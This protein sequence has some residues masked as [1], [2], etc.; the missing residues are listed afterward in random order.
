MLSVNA[1]E[2]SRHFVEGLVPSDAF[3][4]VGRAANGMFETI[5]VVVKIL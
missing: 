3:P 5:F 2:V 1:L 4:A